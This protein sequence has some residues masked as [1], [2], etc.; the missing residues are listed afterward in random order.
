MITIATGQ[1]EQI[2]SKLAKSKINI[3]VGVIVILAIAVGLGSWAYVANTPSHKLS[4]VVNSQNQLSEVSYKGQA[5]V[6]AMTLL[7]RHVTVGVKHYSFGDFVTS[8]NGVVGNGPKYWTFYING[9][10]AAMGA[11]SYVTKNSD[12]LTWKLQ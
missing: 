10:E 9:K 7:E 2:M 1:K 3:I 12:T 4:V 8:I 5:G 6:N 11:S